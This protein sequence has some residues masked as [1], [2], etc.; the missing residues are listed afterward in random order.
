MIK[1]SLASVVALLACTAALAACGTELDTAAETETGE[2]VDTDGLEAAVVDDNSADTGDEDHPPA[3]DPDFVDDDVAFDEGDIENA[4]APVCPPGTVCIENLPFR[5]GTTTVGGTDRFD[6]YNCSSANESGRER[7]YRIA[8]P[9][10][11]TLTVTL[12]STL[13]TGGTDVDVHILSSLRADA[14]LARGDRTAS[15][16]LDADVAFVVF[17]SFQRSTGADGAGGFS[18]LIT[19]QGLPSSERNP[20]IAAGVPPAV[21][22]LAM[23]AWDRAEEQDLTD[24]PVF[25]VIDFSKPSSERRLWTVDVDTGALLASHRVSHGI[26]SN[27]ANDPARATSF[28]NVEGS[29]KSSLGLSRTAETYRGKHGYSLR[30]DGLEGS[31]S[32]MRERAVVVHGASYA[33]DSFASNNGYLGR[34]N[35]CPAIAASRSTAFIDIIKGGTLIFSYFPSASWLDASPFLN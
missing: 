7:I 17:D 34:S 19:F 24:S 10:P 1:R 30:L 33:E 21:A 8:L 27:S 11:G 32:R 5:A 23:L 26:G 35:G 13:E 22:E 4:D 25:T 18:G 3:H 20:L 28:S 12:D 16:T 6:R 15:A 31:N 2:L 9:G 14:C 29:N